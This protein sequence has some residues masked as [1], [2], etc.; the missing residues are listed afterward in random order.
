[1]GKKLNKRRFKTQEVRIL[2]SLRFDKNAST[3]L[4]ILVKMLVQPKVHGSSPAASY[5]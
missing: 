1:M 5:L 3:T 4:K 2:F